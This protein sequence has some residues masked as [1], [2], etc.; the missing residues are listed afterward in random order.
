MK[1]V[2]YCAVNQQNKLYNTKEK[3]K[4]TEM[5]YIQGERTDFWSH[6]VF[7]VIILPCMARH[8]KPGHRVKI[9]DRIV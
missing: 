7:G 3:E 9:D 8:T 4:N 5:L 6:A 2:E 1:L